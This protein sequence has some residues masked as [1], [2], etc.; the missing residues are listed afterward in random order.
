MSKAILAFLVLLALG[1][2]GAACC[3][4]NSAARSTIHLNYEAVIEDANERFPLAVIGGARDVCVLGGGA[5]GMAAAVFAKDANLSVVVIDSASDVGGQCNTL[6]FVPPAPGY[7][8]WID[9]GVQFF[10]DTEAANA[11]G[12]GPWSIDSVEIVR[13]F[14]GNDSVAFLDFTTDATPNYALD[15]AAGI[16]YGLQP[17]QNQTPEF[18]AA[19]GRLQ[20][21]I[22]S[23]PWIDRAEVPS[24]VP[25][26]LLVPFS[27]FIAANQLGPLVTAVFIPQL[28]AGGLGDFDRL[29]TLYALLNLSPTISRIFAVPNAGF[30]VNGGCQLIY[31]GMRA[32][33][34]EN[35]VL[36]NAQ[37]LY[38]A[39]PVGGSGSSQTAVVG[40]IVKTQQGPVS[41]FRYSCGRIIVTYPQTLAAMLPLAPDI[42]EARLFSR[43]DTRSYITGDLQAEVSFEAATGGSF[44]MLNFDFSTPFGTPVLPAITQFTRGLPYGPVQ[45]KASSNT[46]LSTQMARQLIEQ[47]LLGMPES[48]LNNTEVLNVIVH[49]FQPHFAVDELRRA[50]GSYA[51]LEALQGH[52]RTNYLGSL[53][54][55]PVTYTLWNAAYEMIQDIA[56]DFRS[57]H[58]AVV[59]DEA[60]EASLLS[61]AGAW[62]WNPLL[63]QQA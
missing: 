38:S 39:R 31:D 61:A 48:L 6:T 21:I 11:A 50:G 18:Y 16:S 10:A 36:V 42:E 24:P 2:Y 52:R 40:G 54:N 25:S 59:H 3:P 34:G 30:V 47:Q 23:Y 15:L 33:L 5:S 44:N 63:S 49:N 45:F 51:A 1:V 27:D 56:E 9:V 43:V 29:T 41:L 35:N 46:R 53:R 12:L 14:A 26:E 32:Y 7:P 4:S 60:S 20:A 28:L 58:N 37:T 57:Q 19:Y 62:S 13:R 8:A 22:A 55:F 17:P